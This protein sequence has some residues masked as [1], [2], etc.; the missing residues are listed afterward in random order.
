MGKYL[1]ILGLALLIL[2]SCQHEQK[3]TEKEA[4]IIKLNLYQ[5]ITVVK[6]VAESLSS[7]YCKLVNQG[8][9]DSAVKVDS[10]LHK[11]I[12]LNNTLVDS[13][14]QQEIVDPDVYLTRK[15][16]DCKNY[17]H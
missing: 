7:K 4:V 8:K 17:A 9:I 12:R 15:H 11:T 5:Q 14:S 6:E 1:S 13:L 10:L 2:V 16:F 3:M